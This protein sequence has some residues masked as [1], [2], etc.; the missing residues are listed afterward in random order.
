MSDIIRINRVSKTFGEGASMVTAM[1]D[2]SLTIKA[3][4][5]IVF[6]GPS[7]CGKSTLLRMIAGLSDTSRG[8]IMVDGRAVDGRDPSVGMVFQT[9]TSFPWLTV[10][11][12]IGFGLDLANTGSRARTEKVDSLLKRVS[13]TR[14]A[15]SYP[16]QLSGGMQQRVAIARALAVEP[17]ILLMDEPFGALD[18]LTRVEMQTFLLDLWSQDQKTVIFVTH[19]I[20]EAMLL[21]DR[22]VVFSPHP[23]RIAEIIDVDIPHPRTIDETEREDFDRLRHRLRRLLFSM[24]KNAA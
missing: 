4:E 17:Q 9:Y 10:Q 12:N 24:A 22:I 11:D 3:G 19:D 14:F 1:E 15:K 13:L 7:G 20:D 21:A 6:L 8:S 5:F 23:G 2:V 18:A 16:S